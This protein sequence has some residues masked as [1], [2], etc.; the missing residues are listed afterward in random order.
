MLGKFNLFKFLTGA[1]NTGFQNIQTPS[2]Q[3]RGERLL[4]PA[5]MPGESLGFYGGIVRVERG[6][7]NAN[8]LGFKV[9]KNYNTDSVWGLLR[10]WGN[11][12]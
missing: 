7:K 11:T 12:N 8:N 6:W 10:F 9:K 2:P 1:N 5:D 3:G 4:H